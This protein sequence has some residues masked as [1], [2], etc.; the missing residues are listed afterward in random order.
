LYGEFFP[1][2]RENGRFDFLMLRIVTMRLNAVEGDLEA[3][4]AL[5]CFK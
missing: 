1:K 4:C 5:A 2:A 3:K